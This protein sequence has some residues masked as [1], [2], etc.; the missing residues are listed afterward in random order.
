MLL[1]KSTEQS[2]T[3]KQKSRRLVLASADD[4]ASKVI[5]A[6]LEDAAIHFSITSMMKNSAPSPER[7]G[8]R[9]NHQRENGDAAVRCNRGICRECARAGEGA[10]TPLR[11]V[12]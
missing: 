8:I 6:A 4:I 12:P 9:S 1:K 3:R 11:R 5:Q 10:E 2:R 7:V